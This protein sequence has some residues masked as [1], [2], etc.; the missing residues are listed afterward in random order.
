M[1][2]YMPTWSSQNNFSHKLSYLMWHRKI[3]GRYY[4]MAT[5]PYSCRSCLFYYHFGLGTSRPSVEKVN[6]FRYE[7]CEKSSVLA[8]MYAFPEGLAFCLVLY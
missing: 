8:A 5:P 2:F 7:E 4:L 1:P 6:G 3:P